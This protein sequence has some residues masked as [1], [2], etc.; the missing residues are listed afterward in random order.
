MYNKKIME[1]FASSQHMGEIRQA[2]AIGEAGGA[3]VG[4]IFKFYLVVE[5]N[6]IVDAKCKAFGTAVTIAIGSVCAQNLIGL[7]LDEAEDFNTDFV[8]D[9]LGEIPAEKIHCLDLAKEA[10]KNCVIYYH[11]K[12]QKDKNNK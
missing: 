2:N 12:E 9:E 6:E 11:K 10:I 8:L 4:D 1:I 5:K 3:K 7:T